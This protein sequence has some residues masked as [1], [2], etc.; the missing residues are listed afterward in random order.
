MLKFI[1]SG[2]HQMLLRTIRAIFQDRRTTIRGWATY[3][4]HRHSTLGLQS[5]LITLN[6]IVVV[7]CDFLTDDV[8]LRLS[9]VPLAN[10]WNFALVAV[11]IS[12]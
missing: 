1:P 10:R 4:G 7:L 2:K 11:P 8:R 9:M 5:P 6:W 3:K 12:F